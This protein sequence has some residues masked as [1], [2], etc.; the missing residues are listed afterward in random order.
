VSHLSSPFSVSSHFKIL[1]LQLYS[2]QNRLFQLP[3]TMAISVQRQWLP[4]SS[5]R[6]PA[7]P[8]ETDH[9]HSS[10]STKREQH[11]F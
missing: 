6:T 3:E 8:E 9:C 11:G 10:A 5:V 2:L 7:H 1:E 4:L